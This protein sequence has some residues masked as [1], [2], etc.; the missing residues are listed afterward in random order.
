LR[1][2]TAARVFV[3]AQGQ[4]RVRVRGNVAA[5]Q[6]ASSSARGRVRLRAEALGDFFGQNFQFG[7]GQGHVRLRSSADTV[8]IDPHP[9]WPQTNDPDQWPQAVGVRWPQTNDPDQWPA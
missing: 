6:I 2:T 7:S 9:R 8:V 1:S 5:L 3:G 4:G